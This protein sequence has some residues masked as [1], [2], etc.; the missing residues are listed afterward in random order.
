MIMKLKSK[1]I[2]QLVLVIIVPL[3]S[4]QVS[5]AQKDNDLE[6]MGLRSNVKYLFRQNYTLGE[7]NNR[8]EINDLKAYKFDSKGNILLDSD[9]YYSHIYTYNSQDNKEIK[10]RLNQKN[11]VVWKTTYTY[12]NN[13][14][15]VK[16][17][18]FNAFGSLSYSIV[19]KYSPIGLIQERLR[20]DADV[21][22]VRQTKY[23]HNTEGVLWKEV[24][25]N[26][27][28]I[29]QTTTYN[30]DSSDKLLERK[31][32][33]GRGDLLS[34][35]SYKYSREG[36]LV[37]EE[38]FDKND[39]AIRKI[40]LVYDN[41]NRLVSEDRTYYM[42][43]SHSREILDISSSI[44]YKYDDRDN[45]TESK[46]YNHNKEVTHIVK[47]KIV[48]Y[49]SKDENAHPDWDDYQSLSRYIRG[50]TSSRTR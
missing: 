3:L 48:Y 24:V 36:N 43:N 33:D 9:R 16:E 5:M 7:K 38:E 42:P 8:F 17:E 47:R 13:Q 26:N 18:V 40:T 11:E 6:G 45:W 19:Y 25:Y 14:R 35:V 46:V 30:Y 27:N 12:D 29:Y 49:G 32:L 2:K 21:G 37:L 4:L 22:S 39:E 34:R 28:R 41:K 10:N 1:T 44:E 15:L 50:F 20:V 31:E 23:Y